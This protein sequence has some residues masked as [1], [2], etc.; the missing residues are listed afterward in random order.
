[1]VTH[2]PMMIL[3]FSGLTG[4]MEGFCCQESMCKTLTNNQLISPEYLANTS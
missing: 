4:R 2:F 3:L 1:M